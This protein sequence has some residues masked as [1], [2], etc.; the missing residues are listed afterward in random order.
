MHATKRSHGRSDDLRVIEIRRLFR[1][2]DMTDVI[3]IG[4]PDDCTEV[5]RVTYVV[6]DERIFLSTYRR[7]G[8]FFCPGDCEDRVVALYRADGFELCLGCFY[9]LDPL[10]TVVFYEAFCPTDNRNFKI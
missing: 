4:S 2:N 5:T 3:P 8:I 6:E 7:A 10:K 9:D 1:C